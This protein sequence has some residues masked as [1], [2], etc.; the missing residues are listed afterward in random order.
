MSSFHQRSLANVTFVYSLL[1]LQEHCEKKKASVLLD[2]ST[3][4]PHTQSSSFFPTLTVVWTRKLDDNNVGALCEN[5]CFRLNINIYF[6][7]F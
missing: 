7:H 4:S 6:E 3:L 1:N 5:P 2:P